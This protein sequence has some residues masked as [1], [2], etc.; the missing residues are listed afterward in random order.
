M[1]WK[2]SWW[3]SLKN[4]ILLTFITAYTRLFCKPFFRFLILSRRNFIAFSNF[5][6][7]TET[8][9]YLSSL[10]K[11]AII[12]YYVM[13]LIKGNNFTHFVPMKL[14]YEGN[15]TFFTFSCTLRLL[16]DAFYSLKLNFI[17]PY[18]LLHFDWKKNSARNW[19]MNLILSRSF[20]IN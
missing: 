5:E 18:F 7:G 10:I 2:L 17:L 16:Y 4:L 14:Y 13:L 19:Q 9:L 8:F 3:S 15:R 20:V 1:V 6:E 11:N 12:C